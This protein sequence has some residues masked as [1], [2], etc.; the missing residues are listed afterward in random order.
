MRSVINLL[1]SK[2][3]EYLKKLNMPNNLVCRDLALSEKL[4]D[5]VSFQVKPGEILCLS[6]ASGSGK[7]R[8]L[9]ALADLEPHQ[10][11][12]WLGETEHQQIPAHHWRQKLRLVPAESQWWLDQVG[13]HFPVDY[14]ASNLPLLNLPEEA[15]DWQVSRLS[16]G[17][18]QRLGLLRALAWPLEA[19][20]LD[21][22]SANL[23]SVTA[24][25]VENWL[26]ST[27]EQE[28]WPTL[29]VSHDPQ[30]IARVADRHQR[31]C[32]GQL[33]EVEHGGH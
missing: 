18:K 9:R 13:E 22:P 16:S 33:Q 26:K 27:I 24:S 6:G 23:D 25:K 30:Q 3:A 19:L 15:L 21:E 2:L 29:W 17:E 28:G 5:Q 1:S 10:G 32:E 12:V 20:L 11:E 8:L 14:P 7:S 4:L 31:I